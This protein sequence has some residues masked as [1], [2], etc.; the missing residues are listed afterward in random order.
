MLDRNPPADLVCVSNFI[1]EGDWPDEMPEEF[2]PPPPIARQDSVATED[3]A[4]SSKTVQFFGD[5]FPRV[6]DD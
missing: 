1:P 4:Q 2:L 5:E 3:A 6:E